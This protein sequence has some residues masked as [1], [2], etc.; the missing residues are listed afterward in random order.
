M[1]EMLHL[2]P[3][4][5]LLVVAQTDSDA[6]GTPVCRPEAAAAKR[7]KQGDVRQELSALMSDQHVRHATPTAGSHNSDIWG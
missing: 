4:V 6:P 1:D 2:R 3:L 7:T 5:S